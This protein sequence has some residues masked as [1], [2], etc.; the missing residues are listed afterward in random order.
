MNV[1]KEVLES[2]LSLCYGGGI[3]G[4]TFYVFGYGGTEYFIGYFCAGLSLIICYYFVK[5]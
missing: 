3:L 2:G 1:T 5:R 4:I